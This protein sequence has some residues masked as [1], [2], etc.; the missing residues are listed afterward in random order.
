MKKHFSDQ[1]FLSILREAE[2]LVQIN[3]ERV[4]W[5]LMTHIFCNPWNDVFVDTQC[6]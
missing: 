2:V 6:I 4:L 1:E 3:G 5:R